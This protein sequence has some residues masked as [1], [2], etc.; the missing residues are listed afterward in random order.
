M[1]RKTKIERNTSETQ[2][3]LEINL[4]GSG[5]ADIE[6]DIPFFTH[7]L[8]LFARHGLFDLNCKASGDTHIDLHHTVEDIGLTLGEA[9]AKALGGKKGIRRYGSVILPMDEALVTMAVDLGGRPY[10]AMQNIITHEGTIAQKL[11]D[12]L[13]GVDLELIAEFF[14]SF[15]NS[16]QAN[17]HIVLH[18]GDNLHHIIEALFK[19]FGRVLD[20]ASG[21]DERISGQIPSTKGTL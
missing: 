5:K 21:L 8:V 2:I 12:K 20:E 19:A 18:Y 9:V 11:E 15:A 10:F 16:C 1:D 13:V 6:T 4:D 17:L 7:M 3:C 14:R